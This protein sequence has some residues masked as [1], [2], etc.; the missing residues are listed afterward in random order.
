DLSCHTVGVENPAWNVVRFSAQRCAER[1]QLL[2]QARGAAAKCIEAK[3]IR[4]NPGWADGGS[5]SH[6]SKRPLF[7]FCGIPGRATGGEPTPAQCADIHTAG[8]E[9]RL[10][11]IFPGQCRKSSSRSRGCRLSSDKPIFPAESCVGAAG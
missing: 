7:L 5:A 9:W 4:R 3:P 6:R 10:L 2:Q 1:K 11:T 8:S